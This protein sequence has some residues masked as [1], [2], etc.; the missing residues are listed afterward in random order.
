MMIGPRGDLNKI[1]N[2][3][4]YDDIYVKTAQVGA[5]SSARPRDTDEGRRVTP[6]PARISP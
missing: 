2:D 3:G 4:Y 5:S 6:A 1:E